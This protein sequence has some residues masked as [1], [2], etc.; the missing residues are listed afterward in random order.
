MSI[1]FHHAKIAA[2]GRE[3]DARV[4]SDVRTLYTEEQNAHAREHVRASTDLIY[5]PDA[6]HRLDIFAPQ[7]ASA[8]LPILVW[9]HGGGFTR[10]AKS[11]PGHP[12]EAHMGRF[13]VRAGYVG[14]VINYRLAPE[15]VWPA[16]GE[17][18][19]RAVTWLRSNGAKYGGDPTRIILIGTSAGAAHIGTCLQLFP[20][21]NNVS[22][23]VLLSGL[24]GYTECD[25]PQRDLLYYGPDK[26]LHGRC[27][28]GAALE[29]T[30]VPLMVTCAELDPPRFQKEYVTLIYRRLTCQ[31]QLP[32][33]RV[34]AGH[35]HFS[36]P[37]HIGTRDTALSDA[38][39]AFIQK[40]LQRSAV[41]CEP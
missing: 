20:D 30:R 37:Y 19:S 36:L 13:A 41:L 24:Y 29:T 26:S 2:M 33:S 35:N 5:G 28:S 40:S 4:L 10:G 6:R 8:L 23:A 18:I 32:N 16:G 38:I 3:L 31:G 39:L 9:V 15:H 21:A 11:D 7:T 25:D 1:N 34:V 27:A 17:D 22:A 12:Y 14:A